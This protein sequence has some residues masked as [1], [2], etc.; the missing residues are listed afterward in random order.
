MSDIDNMDICYFLRCWKKGAK[1]EHNTKPQI[2]LAV[3]ENG[4]RGM[5]IDQFGLF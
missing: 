4:N 2:P 5:Y 1:T 3:D